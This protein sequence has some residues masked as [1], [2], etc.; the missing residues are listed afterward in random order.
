MDMGI[1]NFLISSTL[2][3]VLAQ[4]LARKLCIHCK[5]ESK[6][7]P[8]IVQEIAVPEDKLYFTSVGCKECDFT[9]YKGR[10]AI[11]ELF[12]IDDE[13]KMMMKDGFND[14]QVREAMKKRG[15]ITIADKLKDMMLSGVTSY[16]EAIRVGLMDG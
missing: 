3:G 11:G 5:E 6:L 14:H 16:E 15:M 8:A 13:V 7:S 2:M 1:E 10:Q 4:R 12:I 9:G